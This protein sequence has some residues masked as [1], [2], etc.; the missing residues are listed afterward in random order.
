[1][2]AIKG[3]SRKIRSAIPVGL[4]LVFSCLVVGTGIVYAGLAVADDF[5]RVPVELTPQSPARMEVV[6]PCVEGWSLD[7]ISGCGPSVI[8]DVWPGGVGLPVQRT[9]GFVTELMGA[10][11][12]TSLLSTSQIWASLVA[13]GFALLILIPVIRSTAEGRPFAHANDRRLGAA[14]AV[15][16]AGWVAATGGPYLAARSAL[17]I[18]EATPRSTGLL[19]FD[20]PAGWLAPDLQIVWWPLLFI[21]LLGCSAAATRHGMRLAAETD[22]LV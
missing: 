4:A 22:G 15:I 20:M 6:L 8:P 7:G 11:A 9:G 21:V 2:H 12:T 17:R 3:T 18:V 10:D 1:M 19:E 13:G 5:V 14:T 16:A